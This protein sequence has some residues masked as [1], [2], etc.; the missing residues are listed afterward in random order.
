MANDAV[1]EIMAD[2]EGLWAGLDEIF[3]SFSASDW[4]RPHGADWTMATVPFHLSYFDR[5]IVANGIEKGPD[6]HVE[7]IAARIDQLLP[8]I[9]HAPPTLI[10]NHPEPDYWY[11]VPG[12]APG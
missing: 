12:E 10:D 9:G 11:P 1:R 3:G 4:D 7:D 6:M 5:D 2:V 8:E